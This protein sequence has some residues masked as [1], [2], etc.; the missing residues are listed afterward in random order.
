MEII[1]YSYKQNNELIVEFI[2]HSRIKYKGVPHD[3]YYN[4]INSNNTSLYIRTTIE[5]K[6]LSES[7][8]PEYQLILS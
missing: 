4:L 6:Y 2:D 5:G 7:L 8:E 1:S 3:V